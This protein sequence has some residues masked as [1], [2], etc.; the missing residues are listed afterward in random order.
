MNLSEIQIETYRKSELTDQDIDQMIELFNLIWPPV[1]P[2]TYEA[3]VA[4]CRRPRGTYDH[5]F[6][7]REKQKIVAHSQIFERKM[8]LGDQLVNVLGLSG[9]CTHPDVRGKKYG[10]ALVQKALDFVDQDRFMCSLFQTEVPDFYSKLNCRLVPN[11]V[12]NSLDPKFQNSSP[13]EDAYVMIYPQ[14]Y[15]EISG[16]ID[17]LGDRY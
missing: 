16:V 11:K 13:F 7:I 12:I 1:N 2:M 5:T 4:K 6:L 8:Q 14:N 9:V 15:P 10:K 17:L 3:H